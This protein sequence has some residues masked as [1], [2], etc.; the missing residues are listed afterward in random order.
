M[1]EK[2]DAYEDLARETDDLKANILETS[3]NQKQLLNQLHSEIL[4]KDEKFTLLNKE[5]EESKMKLEEL[6][7]KKDRIKETC[8]GKLKLVLNNQRQLEGQ[9]YY[10]KASNKALETETKA[11]EK[12]WVESIEELQERVKS[13]EQGL[14]EGS[15]QGS[16]QG[17]ERFSNTCQCLGVPKARI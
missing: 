17:E 15:V 11:R 14:D 6:R 10:A 5:I 3:E 16:D 1:K 9:L 13:L 4:S 8:M 12:K 2:A 7:V